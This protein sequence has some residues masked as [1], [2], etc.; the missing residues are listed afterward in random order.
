MDGERI[1][2]KEKKKKKGLLA[3]AVGAREY[4]KGK[5]YRLKAL[6]GGPSGGGKTQS[7]VTLPLERWQEE[8]PPEEAL[9]V[10]GEEF[11]EEPLKPILVLDFDGRAEVLAGEE[12]IK[13]LRLFD[14][15]PNSPKGWRAGEKI[16]KELWA[17]AKKGV[18]PFSGVVEDS[19]SSMGDSAMNEALTYDTEHLGLGGAPG[20]SHWMPQITFLKNH[21]NSMRMLPCHYILT[22]H[23]EPMQEEETGVIKIYPKVTRSLKSVIPTWF[24]E[25]YFVNRIKKKGK[26][27]YYWNTAGTGKNDFF[28]STLN[29]Q[30]K[31]WS[32]PV[33]INLDKEPR[34]FELLYALRFGGVKQER[35]S[36]EEPDEA[37]VEEFEEEG[38]GEEKKEKE[39]E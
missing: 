23:L 7:V 6:L 26:V 39:R 21:I 25:T 11:I 36:F 10:L 4:G 37:P 1:M 30:G 3:S 5:L 13:I 2:E 32:D 38:G 33:I 18:F 20:R 35:V 12:N 28:K 24:N 31:F 27:I 9:E 16:R 19:L 17:L 15:N 29:A 34:G 8:K 14:P 22:C